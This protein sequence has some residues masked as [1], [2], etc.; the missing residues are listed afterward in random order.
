MIATGRMALGWMLN[1]NGRSPVD[2]SPI[3][4]ATAGRTTL[5]SLIHHVIIALLLI[6]LSDT[7]TRQLTNFILRTRSS[8]PAYSAGR[9]VRM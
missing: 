1:Q 6:P 3:T 7:M 2:Y 8:G 4:A 5:T 9:L